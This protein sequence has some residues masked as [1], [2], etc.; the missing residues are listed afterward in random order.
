MTD[1]IKAAWEARTSGQTYMKILRR[2]A[3]LRSVQA[4]LG[5]IR[6]HVTASGAVQ[7]YPVSDGDEHLRPKGTIELP[8]EAIDPKTFF[9]N[10]QFLYRVVSTATTEMNATRSN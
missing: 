6:E 5:L 10:Q 9:L 8:L 3:D 1:H 4:L 2:E 7:L